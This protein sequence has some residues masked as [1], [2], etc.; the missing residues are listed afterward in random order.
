MLCGP[1]TGTGCSWCGDTW[2]GT[3]DTSLWPP[4]GRSRKHHGQEQRNPSPGGY[5]QR[6]QG[7]G[8]HHHRDHL[9]HQSEVTDHHHHVEQ[10][11][12]PRGYHH[13]H[14]RPEQSRGGSGHPQRA[15]EEDIK[16]RVL[17]EDSP[18]QTVR[19]VQGVGLVVANS[20]KHHPRY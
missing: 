11:P 18:G 9:G 19:M 6:E 13:H 15:M 1:S 20:Y 10:L 12:S 17:V 5:Q 16:T 14:H 7:Q 3:R 8:G 4:G 2:V